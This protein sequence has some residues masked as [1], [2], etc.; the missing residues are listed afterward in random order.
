MTIWLYINS[1]DV[2]Q[3]LGETVGREKPMLRE[4]LDSFTKMQFLF[5]EFCSFLRGKVDVICLKYV[6]KQALIS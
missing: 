2:V 3:K 5:S 6:T 1:Q 4:Q